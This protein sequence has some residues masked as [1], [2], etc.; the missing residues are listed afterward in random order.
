MGSQ[1]ICR[2]I[3]IKQPT[4]YHNI[5]SPKKVWLHLHIHFGLFALHV[6]NTK[7][8]GMAKWLGVPF[9]SNAWCLILESS[10]MHAKA[11]LFVVGASGFFPIMCWGFSLI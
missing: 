4:H 7:N 11:V 2:F 3:E 8:I 6:F 10:H 9:C 5:S 1:I